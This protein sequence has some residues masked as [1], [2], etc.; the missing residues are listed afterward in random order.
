MNARGSGTQDT[1]LDPGVMQELQRF[2]VPAEQ[3]QAHA[4]RRQAAA[5]ASQPESTLKL[6]R[7]LWGAVQLGAALRT[8]VIC[9]AGPAGVQYFGLNYARLDGTKRDLGLAMR[10]PDARA[11]LQQFRVVESEIVNV[12]NQRALAAAEA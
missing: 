9:A 10:G 1:Q 6:A 8:Q 11:L 4:Q 7:H 12:L 5:R 3:L 2:G